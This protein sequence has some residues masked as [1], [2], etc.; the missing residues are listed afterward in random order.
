MEDTVTGDPTPPE[1]P[2]GPGTGPELAQALAEGAL[3]TFL[4][5]EDATLEYSP[6][7]E[8]QVDLFH[9]I[10]DIAV[11]QVLSL[12]NREEVSETYVEFTADGTVGVL[13]ADGTFEHV[14]GTFQ[15]G[16]NPQTGVITHRFFEPD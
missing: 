8:A 4:E 3:D 5:R 13:K 12:D 11:R 6:H 10:P 14:P 2:D 1:E 16:V 15:I 7:V 9:Q